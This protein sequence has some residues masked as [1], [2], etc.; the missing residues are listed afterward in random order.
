MSINANNIRDLP[1][2]S[3]INW[4]AKEESISL[5]GVDTVCYR[6]DHVVDVA[7]LDE[8]AVHLRRHYIRDDELADESSGIGK[9]PS[10]YL[11]EFI[12][13]SKKRIRT[14]DF[15]EIIVS[16]MLQFVEG[17]ESPRYKHHGREDRNDSEHGVDVIAYHA[18]NPTDPKA[19]DELILVEVKSGAGSPLRDVLRRVGADCG[20]DEARRAM[21]L[22][23]IRQRSMRA[24]DSRTAS[25]MSRFLIKGD[26]SYK[27]TY[28]G[29][30]TVG[31]KSLND[32]LD[33]MTAEEFGVQGYDKLFIIHA[34]K[35]IDLIENV[36]D[37]CKQ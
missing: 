27:S 24:G 5:Q 8:W 26:H 20:K 21:T 6:L 4:M 34:D 2:P 25:E 30:A 18:F 9:T 10:D 15:A 22:N 12:I 37:R 23:Y 13:P 33:N 14:G 32:K 28:A 17:F 35:L 36:Y 31:L 11:K 3:F 29:A 7:A 1:K 16:D 19:S